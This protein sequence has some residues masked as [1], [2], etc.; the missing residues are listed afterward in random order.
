MESLM[1][2]TADFNKV[3]ISLFTHAV[4]LALVVMESFCD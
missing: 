2:A 3:A 4:M 1:R